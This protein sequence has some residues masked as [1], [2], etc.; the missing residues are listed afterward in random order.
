[1]QLELLFDPLVDEKF[2]IG[3][4]TQRLLTVGHVRV[5]DVKIA[6][7]RRI[8]LCTRLSKKQETWHEVIC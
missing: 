5:E 6:A 2:G 7:V 4:E 1:L 8:R 3:V